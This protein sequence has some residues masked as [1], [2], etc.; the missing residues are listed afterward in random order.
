MLFGMDKDKSIHLPTFSEKVLIDFNGRK[1]MM[2][3][4]RKCVF[5]SYLAFPRIAMIFSL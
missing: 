3:L 2:S 5:L 4:S 1:R